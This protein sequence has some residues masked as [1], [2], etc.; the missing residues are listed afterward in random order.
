MEE[1]TTP[2]NCINGGIYHNY[3]GLLEKKI[4]D[5]PLTDVG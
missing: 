2:T 1:N 5:I 3:I 4:G